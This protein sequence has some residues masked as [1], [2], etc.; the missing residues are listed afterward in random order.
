MFPDQGR[1]AVAEGRGEGEVGDG[2]GLSVVEWVEGGGDC[3][4]V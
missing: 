4:G 3:G 1:R 2:G